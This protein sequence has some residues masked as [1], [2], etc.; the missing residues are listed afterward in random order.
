MNNRISRPLNEKEAKSLNDAAKILED[1][2]EKRIFTLTVNPSNNNSEE[3][4]GMFL[5]FD[6]KT[7]NKE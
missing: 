5:A 7:G 4:Y 6:L 1:G 3:V 2:F